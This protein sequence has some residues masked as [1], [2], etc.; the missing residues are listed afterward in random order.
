MCR[1]LIML[2]WTLLF[3]ERLA[4]AEELLYNRMRHN[5]S[6][7]FIL[8]QDCHSNVKVCCP[9]ICLPDSALHESA[10]WQDADNDGVADYLDKEPNTDPFAAVNQ[11]GVTMDFDADGCPDHLDANPSI[12]ASD[13]IDS[14]KMPV[15]TCGKIIP[16][17]QLNKDDYD[18]FFDRRSKMDRIIASDFLDVPYVAF[19]SG[20]SAFAPYS[21]LTLETIAIIANRYGTA[22]A[23]HPLLLNEHQSFVDMDEER[24]ASIVQA[25][26]NYNVDSNRICIIIASYPPSK[27]TEEWKMLAAMMMLVTVR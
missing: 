17:Y 5:D 24:V 10:I 27:F 23:I 3:V 13:Y 22:V 8:T 25:L 2:I 11:F 18:V 4:N 7:V 9:F 1:S 14:D 15:D 19:D 20:S 6:I 26:E 21:L 12:G 16:K